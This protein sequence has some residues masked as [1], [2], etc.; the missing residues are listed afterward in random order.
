M[1]KGRMAARRLA[2]VFCVTLIAGASSVSAQQLEWRPVG[3]YVL[4]AGLAAPAGGPV[5][6]VW[7]TA[8]GSRLLIKTASDRIFQT[9][10]FETWTETTASVPE[11]ATVAYV[12]TRPEANALL[13]APATRGLVYAF[14]QAVYRSVDDGLNWD[15]VS[16]ARGQ[17]LLGD[18]LTDLAVSPRNPE[19]IVVASSAGVWRSLDSGL[20]WS[21]LN[22]SLPN[23]PVRRILTAPAAGIAARVALRDGE[24]TWQPGRRTGWISV[25]PAIVK[26]ESDLREALTRALGWE[27]TAVAAAGDWVYAGG[28]GARLYVSPDQGRTWRPFILADSGD[29][30]A[31]YVP[32][33]DPRIALA[34]L[35][36]AGARIARTVNGGIFWE[37]ISGNLPAGSAN[38]VT[39][40]LGSGTVYAATSAGLA[41]T[42][43]DLT[44]AGPVGAWQILS[45]LPKAP[46][47]DA[48]LDDGGHQLY[49]AVEGY[50]VFGATAPHRFR[51]P[52]VVNAADY[53]N[54]PAAPGTLLSVVGAKITS[55]RAGQVEMP[56]LAATEAESQIQVPFGVTGT[57]LA[58]ALMGSGADGAITRR[59]MRMALQATAPA[60]F[61]DRDGTPMALDADR[62]ILL[63]A[64]TSARAGSRV[65]VLATGLGNV[66]PEWPTGLAAP[67]ENAPKVVAPVRAFVDRV[68]VQVTRAT[69]A[70]GYVG[71]YL[72]EF[73]VPDIVNAG[74]AE[75]YLEVGGQESAR[76]TLYLTQ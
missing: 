67:L 17:S 57:S 15:N 4:D 2:V 7:Y 63:D 25:P 54:R 68:P 64:G 60:I 32:P 24:A 1:T 23:F 74:P 47:V 9:S 71:F 41:M 55:A 53:A 5:Q 14:G 49:A 38:G 59:D 56:V 75:F 31:L 65:Q 39:A 22:E 42:V 46:V 10:D 50:G 58:L 27:I 73:Q 66:T 69:L 70:P 16:R 48:K 51:D 52:K 19:E 43:A 37:D 6:R 30:Q 8:D 26:A 36:G 35:S 33:A 20:S 34:A 18:R 29:V 21:G 28:R 44:K 45:G 72:I 11:P 61:V 40:D 76:V 62:S 12:Q 13:R 3:N